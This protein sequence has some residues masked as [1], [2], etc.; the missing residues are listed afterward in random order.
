MDGKDERLR[1]K[2]AYCLVNSQGVLGHTG[3][4][5][6]LRFKEAYCLVESQGVREGG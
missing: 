1:L 2:E 5:L 3:D 4:L 6:R